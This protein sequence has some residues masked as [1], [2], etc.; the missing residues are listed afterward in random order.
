MHHHIASNDQPTDDMQCPRPRALRPKKLL[1][2]RR[3][4]LVAVG[5]HGPGSWLL[6]VKRRTF[7][8]EKVAKSFVNFLVPHPFSELYCLSLYWDYDGLFWRQE[9]AWTLRSPQRGDDRFLPFSDSFLW[10]TDKAAHKTKGIM[11][12]FCPYLHRPRDYSWSK[13]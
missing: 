11:D 4:W 10:M 7:R 5:G 3:T 6:T 2:L 12:I 1:H 13:K 8:V 9:L